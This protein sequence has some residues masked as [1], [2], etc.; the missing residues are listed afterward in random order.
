MSD[1]E[2]GD[3]HG[4][5]LAPATLAALWL[6]ALLELVLPVPGFL[7]LGTLYVLAARPP[8]FLDLVLRLY[9]EPD[10]RGR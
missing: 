8:W 7:T 10:R 6:V 1:D 5:T 9:G 4:A 3:G 2:P